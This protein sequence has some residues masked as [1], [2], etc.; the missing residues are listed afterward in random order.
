MN[1]TCPSNAIK[2]PLISKPSSTPTCN[3]Q[4]PTSIQDKEQIV[5]Y[6]GL[7]LGDCNN[8]T[9]DKVPNSSEIQ[10]PGKYGSFNRN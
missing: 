10:Y 9:V 7:E 5:T 1:D 3:A 4:V 6:L 8:W 2:Q